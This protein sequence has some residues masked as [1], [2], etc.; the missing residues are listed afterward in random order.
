M[1]ILTINNLAAPAPTTLS[2]QLDDARFSAQTALSGTAHV[3]RAAIKRR[4]SVYWAHM[5]AEDL[6]SLLAAVTDTPT[7]LLTFPDPLTGA[8][9]QLRTCPQQRSVGLHRMQDGKP[10]WTNIEITFMEC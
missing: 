7:C 4:V 1:A 3:S 8:M 6:Q 5:N 9:L 2:V 10:T